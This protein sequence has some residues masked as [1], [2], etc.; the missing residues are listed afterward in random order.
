[1]RKYLLQHFNST[2]PINLQMGGAAT[3]FGSIC[4]LQYH[5]DRIAALQRQHPQFFAPYCTPVVFAPA[6]PYRPMT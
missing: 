1:M 3:F 6:I 2:E 4:Y 5:F